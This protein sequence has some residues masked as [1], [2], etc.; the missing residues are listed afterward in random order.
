MEIPYPDYEFMKHFL[1]VLLAF[2]NPMRKS[3]NLTTSILQ[4]IQGIMWYNNSFVGHS[5][6]GAQSADVSGFMNI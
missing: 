6:L 1:R 5:Q 2:H 3:G 4:E